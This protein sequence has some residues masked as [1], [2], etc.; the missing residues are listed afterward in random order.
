MRLRQT[1]ALVLFP[2]ML[3]VESIGISIADLATQPGTG[4]LYGIRA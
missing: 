2:I 1:L 4:V 3:G